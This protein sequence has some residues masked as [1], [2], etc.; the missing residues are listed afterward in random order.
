MAPKEKKFWNQNFGLTFNQKTGGY[1]PANMTT[2]GIDIENN[3]QYDLNNAL[4]VNLGNKYVSKTIDGITKRYI[5]ANV[6][7]DRDAPG[8]NNPHDEDWGKFDTLKETSSRH[9]WTKGT[10]GDKD[11]WEGEVLIPIE[12]EINTATFRTGMNKYLNL[13][14]NIDASAGSAVNEDYA[15]YSAE[16][17]Q[18]VQAEYSKKLGYE[19]T[20]DDAI[21]A[22]DEI[23]NQ[24]L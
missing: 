11:T 10:Y 8:K 2:G 22:L 18:S 5:V 23:A 24:G 9:N 7:Y 17:I 19:V 20:A 15:N 1:N 6:V 14:S 3:E 21:R 13:T 4:A 12:Q 16:Q